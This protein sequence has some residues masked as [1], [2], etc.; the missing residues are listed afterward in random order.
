[1]TKTQIAA[2]QHLADIVALVLSDAPQAQINKYMLQ[3]VDALTAVDQATLV[4]TP[5]QR[6]QQARRAR[7]RAAT[8]S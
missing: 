7:D 6:A 1:M 5:G 4:L 2:Y 3:M 8:T